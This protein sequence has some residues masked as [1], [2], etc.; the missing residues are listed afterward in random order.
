MAAASIDDI[1]AWVLLAVVVATVQSSMSLSVLYIIL[2]MFADIVLVFLV[3]R[4]I[5]NHLSIRVKGRNTLSTSH[6]LIVVFVVMASSYFCVRA[7][8]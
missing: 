1:L 6:F 8:F 3:I 2:L 5:L 4:P 7:L